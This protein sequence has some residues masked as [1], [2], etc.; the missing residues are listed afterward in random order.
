MKL[1]RFLAKNCE[2]CLEFSGVEFD[3]TGLVPNHVIPTDGITLSLFYEF[4]DLAK[5]SDCSILK[6]PG[7]IKGWNG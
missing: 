4:R 1:K 2:L 3:W 5:S 7:F 6:Q